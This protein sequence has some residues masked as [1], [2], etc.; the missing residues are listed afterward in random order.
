MIEQYHDVIRAD[1]AALRARHLSEP[2][3]DHH[4]RAD[5][6]RLRQRGHAGELP[7]LELRQGVHRHREELQARPDGPRLRDRHQLRPVHLLP[8]GGEHDGDAGARHRACRL[9][10]QQLLQGQLPV[11]HV[12]GRVVDHRLPRLLEELR[13]RVR[14][15]LRPRRRRGTARLL[16]RADEPRRR[17]LPAAEQALAGAGAGA[18]ARTARPTRSCR[19]TTCGA[20]CR[21]RPT[22]DDAAAPSAASRASRRRTCCTSSRRTRRCWSPGSARSCASCARS[23]STSIRSARR[24]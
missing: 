21:A 10:P 12:D 9:R 22:S 8:D 4:L 5:D 7:P 13:R 17:P 16:P 11:P 1:R 24:R 6:G 14:G 23:R 2:A 20:R 18:R 19:S 15:A 3:R